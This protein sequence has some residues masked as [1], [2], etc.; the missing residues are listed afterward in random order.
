LQWQLGEFASSIMELQL[1]LTPVLVH[2]FIVRQ[3]K[4]IFC[5]IILDWGLLQN[6]CGSMAAKHQ[7]ISGIAVYF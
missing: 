3:R 4:D 1:P 5:K 6:Q 2:R 7:R